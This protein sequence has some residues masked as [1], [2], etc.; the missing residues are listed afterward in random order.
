MLGALSRAPLAEETPELFAQQEPLDVI[1]KVIGGHAGSG[2]VT[3]AG[4]HHRDPVVARRA[5]A[6]ATDA[7]ELLRPGSDLARLLGNFD[8]ADILFATE[9]SPAFDRYDDDLNDDEDGD[10]LT[11]DEDGDD[12]G[13]NDGFDETI[14]PDEIRDRAA[15]LGHPD[16]AVHRLGLRTPLAPGAE[17]DL[18]AGLS[19]LVGF[20]PEPGVYCLAPAL[21]AG[22]PSG[23]SPSGSSPSGEEPGAEAV[24]RAAERIARVY[25]L[26]LLRYRCLGFA[27]VPDQR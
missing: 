27:L 6:V 4:Q 17:D 2:G 21:S 24:A 20:D 14:A 11:D 25:G 18:V 10:D 9:Q 23:S 8:R 22:T 3:G 13:G 26:P 7:M 5:V 12:S 15:A 16:L 1:G 19:E